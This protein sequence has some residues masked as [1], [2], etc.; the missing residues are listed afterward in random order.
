MAV[1]TPNQPEE[2]PTQAILTGGSR[3]SMAVATP[4][5][6]EEIPTQAILTGGSRNSMAVVTPNQ[7]EEHLTQAILTGGSRNSMAVAT[8]YQSASAEHLNALSSPYL[9]SADNTPSVSMSAAHATILKGAVD[10]TVKSDSPEAVRQNVDEQY[11]NA[12]FEAL[13]DKNNA[14]SQQRETGEQGNSTNQQNVTI[15]PTSPSNNE[16]TAQFVLTT[17]GGQIPATPALT[18]GNSPVVPPA[19]FS[20]GTPVPAEEIINHLVDRFSSNPRL[21]TSK[22]SL[23]LNPAEL[24]ALKID[25]MVKG[26]SIKA[27]IIANSQQIQETIEKH[28]PKLRTIL[29]QQGFTIEDFQVTQESTSSGSNEFFQKHFSSGQESAPQTPLAQSETPFDLSLHSAEEILSST[30][31]DSGINLSI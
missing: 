23:N 8:P 2:I 31:T 15:L 27:H 5:Q 24:G 10:G 14:R 16:Q 7:P 3:N 9:P 18:P 22:I 17:P 21:Q 25:I 30:A 13:S 6:P 26:D 11:L 19:T 28:M 29:E 12:K 20:P 4:N 1:V